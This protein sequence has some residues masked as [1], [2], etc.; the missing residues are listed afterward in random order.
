MRTP[1]QIE[2]S[3]TRIR[4]RYPDISEADVSAVDELLYRWMLLLFRIFSRKLDEE[5]ELTGRIRNDIHEE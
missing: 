2:K 4:K 3:K 5:Q 1:E